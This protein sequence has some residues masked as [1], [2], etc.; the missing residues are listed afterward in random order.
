MLTVT[1]FLFSTISQESQGVRKE[2]GRI[3]ELIPS[4]LARKIQYPTLFFSSDEIYLV[5]HLAFLL[6]F[7]WGTWQ[8]CELSLY[9]YSFDMY[10][11]KLD[12]IRFIPPQY[13]YSG[14]SNSYY[15]FKWTRKTSFL[16]SSGFWLSLAQNF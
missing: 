6:S 5:F 15:W 1:I 9:F 14:D 2:Y 10:L 11:T 13:T 3:W 7:L 12:V 8:L 16:G 4:S